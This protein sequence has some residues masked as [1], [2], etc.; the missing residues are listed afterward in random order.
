MARPRRIPIVGTKDYAEYDDGE[1]PTSGDGE[2]LCLVPILALDLDFIVT[3]V[4]FDWR[5]CNGSS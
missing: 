4:L 2:V 5:K 1:A 3:F